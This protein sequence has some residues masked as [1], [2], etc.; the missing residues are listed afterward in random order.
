MQNLFQLGVRTRAWSVLILMGRTHLDW[1]NP[2]VQVLES[3]SRPS[4]GSES[5]HGADGFEWHHI[6]LF[7][8]FVVRWVYTTRVVWWMIQSNSVPP[9]DSDLHLSPGR[10]Q[11]EQ[12]CRPDCCHLTAAFSTLHT[13]C[14]WFISLSLTENNMMPSSISLNIFRCI[15]TLVIYLY[16][17][18]SDLKLNSLYCV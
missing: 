7:S 6:V 12:S 3:C 17:S 8:C 14:S 16:L 5:G 2:E 10:P 15:F 4:L 1:R 18:L 13:N 11:R 9:L